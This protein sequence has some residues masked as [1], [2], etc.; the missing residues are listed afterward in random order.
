MSEQSETIP[1]LREAAEA[2]RKAVTEAEQLKRENAFLKAGLDPE[3]PKAK[4]FVKGYDGELTKEAIVAEA[5]AAGILGAPA[6]KAEEPPVEEPPAG[7][8]QQPSDEEQEFEAMSQVA[9]GAGDAGAPPQVDELEAGWERYGQQ[10][11]AGARREDAAAAVLG[12][13]LEGAVKGDERFIV[14]GR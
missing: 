12:T 4:Y 13:I 10:R 8:R 6:P 1:Q 7:G 14:K 9:A 11:Q 2:G 3:D 5:T